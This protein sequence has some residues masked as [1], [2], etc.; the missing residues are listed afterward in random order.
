MADTISDIDAALAA[1]D[2][3]LASLTAIIVKIVADIQALLAEIASGV[4][5]QDVTAEVNKIQSQTAVLQQAVSDL[6]GA[7]TSANA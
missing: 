7:D 1:E 4:V 5:L 2:Q 6:S 3:T